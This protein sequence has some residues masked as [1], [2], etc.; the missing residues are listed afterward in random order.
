MSNYGKILSEKGKGKST[1]TRR[2]TRRSETRLAQGAPTKVKGKR[3]EEKG[4]NGRC[5]VVW[6]GGTGGLGF[7]SGIPRLGSKGFS[8]LQRR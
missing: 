3:E 6:C 1:H 7:G 4:Y 2:E 8:S 5:G